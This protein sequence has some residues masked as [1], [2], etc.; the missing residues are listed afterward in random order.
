MSPRKLI[1]VRDPQGFRPLAFGK[2]DNGIFFSSESCALEMVGAKFI[3]D[4][5]PGEMVVLENNK[6]KSYDVLPNEKHASCVFEYIYFA[7]PDST[8]DGIN[9]HKFRENAGRCL[10]RQA[11]VD[12]DLVSG[13]PDSGVD[14]AIGYSKESGIPYDIVFVKSKYIGRSFIQNSQDK[15]QNAVNLKLNPL[16][17]NVMGKKIVLIDDS[18][19]RG[20]T[21]TN[22][23]K[24]L[25][26]AG[27]AEVHIRIASPAFLDVCYFGTDI[28][29]K[30]NLIASNKTVEEIRDIIGADS[31]E[32]L[33]LE[34]LEKISKDSFVNGICTGC[35]TSK[36]PIDVPDT[37][38]KN[39]FESTPIQFVKKKKL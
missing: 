31:L 10:A 26:D 34:N 17:E 8:I 20:N 4:V 2:D 38:N 35:F 32:Y 25:K 24:T 30:E 36:Y 28:D 19:V 14:A 27:A 7:R 18:I 6:I 37:I 22:I 12:A 1:A 13:V 29:S 16:K 9:V 39:R 23:I 33:S 11:P 15:R 3:R 21:L 5:K